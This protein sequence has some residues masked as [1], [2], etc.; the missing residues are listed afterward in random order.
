M[1][2][3]LKINKEVSVRIPQDVWECIKKFSRREGVTIDEAVSRL[4]NLN[5]HSL[6]EYDDGPIPMASSLEDDKNDF[7]FGPGYLKVA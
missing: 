7:V 5:R 4:L 6:S 2:V 1:G 3:R